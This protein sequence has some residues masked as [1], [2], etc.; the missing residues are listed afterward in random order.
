MQ[1]QRVYCQCWRP[2][3]H[4]V[5]YIMARAQTLEGITTSSTNLVF[6]LVHLSLK[7][8]DKPAE[9]TNTCFDPELQS[10]LRHL[11]AISNYTSVPTHITKEA[12]NKFNAHDSTNAVVQALRAS[13]GRILSIML[14]KLSTWLE[15]QEALNIFM[16][17]ACVKEAKFQE[18]SVRLQ[19][20][21]IHLRGVC[22]AVVGDIEGDEE[23]LPTCMEKVFDFVTNFFVQNAECGEV[24][25]AFA[26]ALQ[27]EVQFILMLMHC[28]SPIL[29]CPVLGCDVCMVC[30]TG[31]ALACHVVLWGCLS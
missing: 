30:H 22:D 10:T 19:T 17:V 6:S 12:Y 21:V 28:P 8:I 27:D 31:L 13:C 14:T 25:K 18:Y 4:R 7:A 5:P 9:M 23:A 3:N 11:F 24:S 26:M 29:F 15:G 1:G 16:E 20:A 2:I